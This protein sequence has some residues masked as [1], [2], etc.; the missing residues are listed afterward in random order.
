MPKTVKDAAAALQK[1]GFQSRQS[2]HVFFHLV[3]DGR[4]TIISTKI[5]HGE[6]EI[7]DSL[8]GMMARQI[9]LSRKQFNDLI[10]CPLSHSDYL[11]LLRVAGVI[12][13]DGHP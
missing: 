10:D 5:S 9:R 11:K 8:L 4:K 2:H 12:D 3:V 7:A 13:R 6:R 1:K